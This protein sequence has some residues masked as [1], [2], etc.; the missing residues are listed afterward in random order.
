MPKCPPLIPE[1]V[2][3]RFWRYVNKNGPVHPI[4]GQCWMWTGPLRK[5]GSGY[6]YYYRDR[7]HRVSWRLHFGE[8]PLGICV[9]HKCDNPLCVNP[10][11]LFLGTQADNNRDCYAKN[12]QNRKGERNPNAKLTD[13]Q[14]KEVRR[15]YVKGLGGNSKQ[16]AAEYGILQT[17]LLAIANHRT[18]R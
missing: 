11:H 18:K 13:F 15:R 14:V 6:G 1:R 8:I 16:L 12:R 2:V 5:G 4:Y 9:C 3:K 17:S 10:S 7:A